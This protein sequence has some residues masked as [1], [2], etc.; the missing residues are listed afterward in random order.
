[1]L[2]GWK[3][4]IFGLL[5]VVVPPALTYLGGINWVQLGVSPVAAAIIGAL[6]IGLRA[7]TDTPIGSGGKK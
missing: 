1:M 6:I 4:T 7:V 2:K 3:T 5:V